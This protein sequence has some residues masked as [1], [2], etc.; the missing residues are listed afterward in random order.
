[1]SNLNTRQVRM[2]I[3]NIFVRKFKPFILA[4]KLETLSSP[5][6]F[7]SPQTERLEFALFSFKRR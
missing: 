7:L 4:L 1:M 3:F 2:L 6:N 5:N